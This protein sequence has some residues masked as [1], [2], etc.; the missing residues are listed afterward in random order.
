MTD[1]SN[2]KMNLNEINNFYI[3]QV[4]LNIVWYIITTH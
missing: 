2:I 3:V 1:K 4:D